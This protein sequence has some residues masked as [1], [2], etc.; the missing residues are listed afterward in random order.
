MRAQ[1]VSKQ[2]DGSLK[3][4]VCVLGVTGAVGGVLLGYPFFGFDAFWF[5]SAGGACVGII[6]GVL[7]KYCRF[8]RHSITTHDLKLYATVTLLG[9]G[10]VCTGISGVIEAER[11]IDELQHIEV[12][13]IRQIQVFR[14]FT[15]DK[16][17]VTITSRQTI[18]D[19]VVGVRDAR[20]H[21]PGKGMGHLETVW[22]RLVGQ[23]RGDIVC[24]LT[25]DDAKPDAVQGEILGVSGN[26]T[27]VLARFKSKQLRDWF[28]KN[29]SQ[30]TGQ[31]VTA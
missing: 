9:L 8:G 21:H 28:I 13:D 27:V 22:I 17:D 4:L 3:R 19:F 12:A 2:P 23:S 31:R 20:R 16:V 26:S 25:F 14:R 18:T 7:Q 10:T 15:L 29:L 5:G 24:R 11:Q 1:S 30:T 6:I